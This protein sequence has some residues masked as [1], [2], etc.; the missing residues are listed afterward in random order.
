MR[1]VNIMLYLIFNLLDIYIL[2]KFLDI[3]L[4]AEGKNEKR[5]GFLYA[6]FCIANSI[7]Y[8]C[9]PIDVLN[10]A[11][12]VVL[13]L[14]LA[15]AVYRGSL[16]K[17]LAAV[18][19]TIAI[20]LTIESIIILLANR[21]I[22]HISERNDFNMTVIYLYI[23]L[24]L[25]W[26][27]EMVIEKVFVWGGG[28]QTAFAQK[29]LSVSGQYTHRKH[30]FKYNLCEG[31]FSKYHDCYGRRGDHICNKCSYLLSL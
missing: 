25:F 19:C 24:F 1:T 14:L 16:W 17:K 11:V 4:K 9:S 20:R 12:L 29:L 26:A 3:F 6:L 22:S 10:L 15:V 31:G 23:S 27:V 8:L 5:C 21:E 18:F 13:S 30:G 2:I 7:C 28:K